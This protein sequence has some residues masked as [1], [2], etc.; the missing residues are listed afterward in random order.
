MCVCVLDRF[1]ECLTVLPKKVFQNLD[2]TLYF[3]SPIFSAASRAVLNW[4]QVEVKGVREPNYV[5]LSLANLKKKLRMCLR[6]W[7]LVQEIFWRP[8]RIF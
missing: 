5:I 2:D 8:I 4:L 7:T 1:G 6:T 3:C